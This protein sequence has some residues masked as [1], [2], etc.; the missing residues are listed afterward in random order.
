MTSVWITSMKR[1]KNMSLVSSSLPVKIA[2]SKEE[3]TRLVFA[4]SAKACRE[5]S[6][7]PRLPPGARW[8]CRGVPARR[9]RRDR[10]DCS[11]CA[12]AW[13]CWAIA[14]GPSFLRRL[15]CRCLSPGSWC[16]W[17]WQ[18]QVEK[19]K[20]VDCLLSS[21]ISLLVLL[22]VKKQSWRTQQYLK[23]LQN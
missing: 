1:R 16:T 17:K 4:V 9:R 10:G 22:E 21:L 12:A 15:W 18:Q 6:V 8:S 19:K 2:A 14:R 20:T 13:G 3:T 23:G 11:T 5:R 7:C